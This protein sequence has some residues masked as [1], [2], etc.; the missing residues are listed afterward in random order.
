[1]GVAVGGIRGPG[2]SVPVGL[3][4]SQQLMALGLFNH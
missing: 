4:L 1:M 3:E 2:L